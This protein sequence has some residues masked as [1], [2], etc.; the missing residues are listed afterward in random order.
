MIRGALIGMIFRHSLQL[1]ASND[2]SD[3]IN[4]MSTDIDRI[5]QTLQWVLNVFPNIIQVGLALWILYVQLGLV[6]ISPLVV[7]IGEFSCNYV[8]S[9][10]DHV[11]SHQRDSWSSWTTC[12]STTEE[13]DAEYSTT[14]GSYHGHHQE[15]QKCKVVWSLC[16]GDRPD[17][18]P[19]SG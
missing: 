10:A 16:Q 7:A 8:R 11:F 18:V 15:H 12:S 6:F 17:H 9:F 19:P 13:M 14:S 3:A 1:V 2:A 5:T 4:L